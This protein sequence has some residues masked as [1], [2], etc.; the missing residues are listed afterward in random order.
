[1]FALRLCVCENVCVRVRV[2]IRGHV[3]ICARAR[4]CECKFY[5]QD[6]ACYCV[7]LC[8]FFSACEYVFVCM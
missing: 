7:C 2:L 6:S 8:A 3:R 1:M 5:G 4:L